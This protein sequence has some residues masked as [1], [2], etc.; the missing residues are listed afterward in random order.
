MSLSLLKQTSTPLSLTVTLSGVEGCLR[1]I[2][3][4]INDI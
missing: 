3:P 2:L 1:F 4:K